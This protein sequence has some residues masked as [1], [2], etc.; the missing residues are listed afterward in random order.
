MR[1][2]LLAV[3]SVLSLILCAAMVG[4]WVR[5]YSVFDSLCY[6]DDRHLEVARRCELFSTQGTVGVCSFTYD[7]GMGT[8]PGEPLEDSVP[9]RR[10][11]L[12]RT[13]SKLYSFDLELIRSRDEGRY[14]LGFGRYADSR[15]GTWIIFIPDWCLILCTLLLTA[16]SRW[17]RCKSARKKALGLCPSCGYDLRANP[18]RC[19]ECGRPIVELAAK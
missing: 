18:D 8:L 6:I 4:L 14:F 1:R 7:G 2:R 5:S 9:G 13:A 19:P 16:G 3:F 10:W 11:R 12:M 15:L 17:A